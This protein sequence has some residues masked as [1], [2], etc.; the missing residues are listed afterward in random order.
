MWSDQGGPWLEEAWGKLGQQEPSSR[1][2][3][4]ADEGLSAACSP[5]LAG[6]TPKPSKHLPFWQG[7]EQ[8]CGWAG[9][10]PQCAGE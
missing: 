2:E 1:A 8:S 3:L 9:E 6:L 7:L 4:A 5:S 10:R